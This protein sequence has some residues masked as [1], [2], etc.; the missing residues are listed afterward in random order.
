MAVK[1]WILFTIMFILLA[2]LQSVWGECYTRA[3]CP[4]PKNCYHKSFWNKYKRKVTIHFC[5]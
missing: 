5:R 2:S 4:Y 1:L 3:E